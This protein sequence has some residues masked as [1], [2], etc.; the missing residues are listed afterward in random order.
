M[1]GEAA[2]TCVTPESRRLL[3]PEATDEGSP[4]GAILIKCCHLLASCV[5]RLRIRSIDVFPDGLS[6]VSRDR[7][8][9]EHWGKS[10]TWQPDLRGREKHSS[11][12]VQAW[13]VA[14]RWPDLFRP[15]LA[16]ATTTRGCCQ[17]MMDPGI[18]LQ[19]WC[20]IIL[21][22]MRSSPQ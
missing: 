11:L 8:C 5:S 14:A 6:H 22:S 3:L 12:R 18:W 10:R 1:G 9:E 20:R 2:V 17:S 15:G 19:K 4:D 16:G 7:M 13:K 21:G